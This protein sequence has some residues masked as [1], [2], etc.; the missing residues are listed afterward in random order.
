MNALVLD[1][2]PKSVSRVDRRRLA[3]LAHAVALASDDAIVLDDGERRPGHLERLHRAGDPGV[4]VGRLRRGVRRGHQDDNQQQGSA[5]GHEGRGYTGKAAEPVRGRWVE[6]ERADRIRGAA[7][8]ATVAGALLD[9]MNRR[10]AMKTMLALPAIAASARP[11]GAAGQ[12]GAWTPLFD[13]RDLAGWETF[14]GKPHQLVVVPGEP[15][16]DRGEYLAPIGV[17]RDPTAVF[18]VVEADGGPAIRVSGEIYGALTTRA[19][20]QNYHLRFDSNGA[21]SGGRRV[22]RCGATAAAATTRSDRTEQA[23]DSGCSRANSRSR[24]AS[25]ETS[26][27]SPG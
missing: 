10:T 26:T 19:E 25:A 12:P 15:K 5:S 4:E 17:G 7:A 16:D 20:Y 24:K 14:L 27:V 9:M 2:M 11:A 1:A 6:G 23:M 13:G 18:S 21:R 3:E 8:A 22:R